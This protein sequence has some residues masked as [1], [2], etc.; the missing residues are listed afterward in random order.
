MAKSIYLLSAVAALSM[1]ATP[2][3]AAD[4]LRE[5]SQMAHPGLFAGATFRLALDGSQARPV[6]RLGLTSYRASAASF[7]QI[8]QGGLQ[9]GLTR[10]GW[11][12]LSIAG[13]PVDQLEQRMQ[14][15]GSSRT[16]LIVGGVVVVAAAVLLVTA[17]DNDTRCGWPGAPS[18]CANPA[19]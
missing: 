5:V 13:Q 6:A 17:D 9:I 18:G 14:L 2:A 15:N 7:R 19:D 1:A 3:V 16:L 4:D 8:G 10:R 11:T 12:Q